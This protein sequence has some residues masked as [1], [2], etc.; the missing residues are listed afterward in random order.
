MMT[1]FGTLSN[2]NLTFEILIQKMIGNDKY[3]GFVPDMLKKL[4]QILGVNFSINLVK[5]GRLTHLFIFINK[6]AKWTSLFISYQI[7]LFS[8]LMEPNCC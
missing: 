6:T 3:E 5:D 1:K 4:T 2:N 7:Q 8:T